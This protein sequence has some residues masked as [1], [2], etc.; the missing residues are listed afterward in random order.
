MT[1]QWD[2]SNKVFPILNQLSLIEDENERQKV[3]DEFAQ[4]LIKE[5]SKDVQFI[6]DRFLEI[7]SNVEATGVPK[8]LMDSL[9]ESIFCYVNGQYLSTIATVGI[10]GELFCVH[11]YRLYLE[12]L[13]LER[14]VIKRRLEKFSNIS[15]NEKIDTLFA[16][17]GINEHICQILHSIKKKRNENIHPHLD[18]DYKEDALDCL[19]NIVDVLNMY[20]A[21]IRNLNQ[22]PIKKIKRKANKNKPPM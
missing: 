4:N 13:G 14:S 20:S 9:K 16:V 7:G 17:I 15:Q 8:S 3:A 6:A 22:T 11:I 19:Q 10:T 12:E 1:L 5:Y 21:Y 18:K 2:Y